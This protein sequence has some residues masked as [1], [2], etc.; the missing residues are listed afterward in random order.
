MTEFE[1]IQRYFAA[2]CAP[3]ADVALGVGDDAAVLRP[4]PGEELAVTTDT[5]IEGRHFP[6]E[7]APGDVGWKALAVNLSDL[8]AMGAQPRWFVLALTL[9]PSRAHDAWLAA[10]AEGLARL[11]REAGVALVGGDTTRGA[12]SVTIT[13]LGTVPPGAALRRSGAQVGDAVC[14]TGTLG[15]AAL[16]LQM[17][18]TPSQMHDAQTGEYLFERLNRPSPRLAAGLAL[19]DLANAAIDLSD[20][21]AGDLKHILEASGVGA[22][23]EIDTLPM[24]AAFAR[25]HDPAQRL[26][27]QACGGDDYELCLCIPPDRLAQ[28]RARV[29]AL[30]LTVIGRIR[31]EP[32][33]VWR[34]ACG[35]P[36]N[37]D[38]HG[39]RHFGD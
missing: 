13:A 2:Q 3:R 35:K 29:E 32:G 33:L 21:L 12:L 11:A 34:D 31:D 37:L 14:V 17:L 27:L 36:L 26:R 15:D 1:L 28:A 38:L 8:A 23:I 7:A 18:Q 4:P 24:S 9:E 16:A 25:L 20:G 19:R 30:P 10:F 6:R 5:L 39:Y 22:E